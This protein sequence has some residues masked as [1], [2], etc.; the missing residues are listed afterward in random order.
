VQINND[1]IV[2]LGHTDGLCNVCGG[3]RKYAESEAANEAGK[4][5]DHRV[6]LHGFLRN[7]R[8]TAKP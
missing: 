5:S 3:S 1:R 7:P 4:A 6:V 2:V 8:G